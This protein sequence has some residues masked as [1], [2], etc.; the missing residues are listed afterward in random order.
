MRYAR[1]ILICILVIGAI[2]LSII[3]LN[4]KIIYEKGKQSQYNG[5]ANEDTEVKFESNRNNQYLCKKVE[6]GYEITI[7][8]SSNAII[9]S[10][11]Y[12]EEPGISWVTEN[13]IEIAISVGSPARY[14]YYVD[15]EEAKVSDIF[16]N[17][18]F[19]GDE[20]VAY[21]EDGKLI[22]CN[23]FYTDQR[24]ETWLYME[25]VRDY[26]QTANPMSAIIQIEMYDDES[27]ILTYLLGD[28]Y[29][30]VSEIIK[31]ES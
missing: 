31:L 6:E 10:E 26:T 27:I 12:P 19:V 9:L 28:K 30:E 14:V 5:I 22:L 16:F 25:I 23:M 21:M 29:E 15:L 20:Y 24:D 11:V 3:S 8:N 4:H 2:F 13:I 18:I 1:K 17:S 7:Y